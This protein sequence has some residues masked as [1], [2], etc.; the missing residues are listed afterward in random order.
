MLRLT[1]I[2]PR[3]GAFASMLALMLLTACGGDQEPSVRA[4]VATMNAPS[5]AAATTSAV[6][7]GDVPDTSEIGSRILAKINALP[8]IDGKASLVEFRQRSITS[9]A[10]GDKIKSAV[11][12]FEG[13]VTFSSDVSWSW[14]GPTKAGEPQKFEARAD[15][16]NQ[17]RG[18]QLVEP[19]GIYPL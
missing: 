13:I 10:L 4:A 19:L 1:P 8:G 2:R 5:A 18:W 14:Q 9:E 11:V 16:V 17:G 6:A 3:I 7:G 15:Y 12:E